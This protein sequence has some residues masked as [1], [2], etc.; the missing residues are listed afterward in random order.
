MLCIMRARGS[1]RIHFKPKVMTRLSMVLRHR[2]LAAPP[3]AQNRGLKRTQ[4]K[5]DG[6]RIHQQ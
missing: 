6:G 2:R 3:G 4:G 5:N 1:S